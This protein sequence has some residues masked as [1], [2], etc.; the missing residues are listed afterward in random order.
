MPTFNFCVIIA[1]GQVNAVR[2]TVR[3]IVDASRLPIAIVCVGVGDGPWG[4]MHDFDDNLPLATPSA[5]DGRLFDNFR[6]I[7]LS[8]IATRAR[9]NGYDV[10]EL[11]ALEALDE[12]PAAFAACKKLR[13][14]QA[15]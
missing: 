12:V 6:F 2:E 7:V 10:E 8:D 14:L 4:E 9:E 13:L 15:K 11:I 1:D 5:P 3:A